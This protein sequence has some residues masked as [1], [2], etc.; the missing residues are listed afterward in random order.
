MQ[1]SIIILSYNTRDLL[2]SCIDSVQQTVKNVDYEIIVIDNNSSDDSVFYL[3]KNYPK[4]RLIQNSQNEGFSKANNQGAKIAKGDWLLFLNSDTKLM[5]DSLDSLFSQKLDNNT[6][7]GCQL[8]NGDNSLQPSAGYFPTLTRVIAQM[9]FLDDLPLVK[10]I[11]KSYQ[12]TNSSFYQRNQDVDWV[13]GAF[14]LI[15]KKLFEKI[16][17]FD[18]SIFMYAEEVD[19]CFKANNH[20]A[21]VKY[22]SK[23]KVIHYKGASS[24]DGFTAAVVGE[25]KGLITFY[26]KNYPHLL[27]ILKAVL[28]FGALL[29]IMLFTITNPEKVLAYQKTIK[30]LI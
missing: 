20:N 4:V 16:K 30:S 18:E 8:L 13:T 25:F 6:I 10:K 12:Q 29:R 27:P 21:S 7:F 3:K 14:L 15:S 1:L 23:P 26:S 22:L 9:F 11:I 19:L 28:Y 17:G 2:T 5:P 24:K